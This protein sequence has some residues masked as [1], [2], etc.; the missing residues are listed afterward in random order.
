MW[1]VLQIAGRIAL[2]AGSKLWN[3][4][5]SPWGNG[6]ITGGLVATGAGVAGE[7]V[8]NAV[9][10]GREF[11]RSLTVLGLVGVVVYLIVKK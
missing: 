10:N 7:K 6:A 2:K 11:V 9:E 3:V 4:I 1:Q 5:K 8:E